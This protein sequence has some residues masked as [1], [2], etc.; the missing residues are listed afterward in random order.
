MASKKAT[1]KKTAVQPV[2]PVMLPALG[3]AIDA[4]RAEFFGAKGSNSNVA[5]V[6]NWP[7]PA[8]SGSWAAVAST[9][10]DGFFSQLAQDANIPAKLLGLATLTAI[11]P[12]LAN[13][14]RPEIRA[15]C[16]IIARVFGLSDRYNA[17]VTARNEKESKP[18]AGKKNYGTIDL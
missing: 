12:D 4:V 14:L 13:S 8:K 2:T 3:A 5:L 17:A 11:R 15:V 10:P 6:Q 9:N 7:V 18:T 1:S 16:E